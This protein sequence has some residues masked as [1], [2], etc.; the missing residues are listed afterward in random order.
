[1]GASARTLVLGW[2][3]VLLAGCGLTVPQKAAIQRFA[4]ATSSLATVTSRELVGTRADVIEMNTLRVELADDTVAIDRAASFFTVDRVKARIDALTA[5]KTYAEL[6]EELATGSPGP[7]LNTTADDFVAGLRRLPGVGLSD[8]GADGIAGAVQKI[9]GFFVEHLRAKAI[10]EIVDT[11]H[12]PILKLV[13]LVGRDFDPRADHWS[14]GYAT[15]I[16][17]LQGAAALAQRGAAAASQGPLI[18]RARVVA[19]NNKQRFDTVTR[20]VAASVLALRQAQRN[21]RDVLVMPGIGVAHIQGYAAHVDDFVT[22][23]RIVRA[24]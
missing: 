9:G 11:T 13:D 3:A 12:E 22:I 20:Q 15:T 14:L 17:A 16:S 5:L 24:P 21:L 8:G 1:V 4:T 6:L 23:H 18:G 7:R 2:L 10:R 19:E